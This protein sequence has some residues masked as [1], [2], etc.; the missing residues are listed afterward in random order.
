MSNKAGCR[1]IAAA[2]M[3][4][5]RGRSRSAY[6]TSSASPMSA[7]DAGVFISARIAGS[8]ASVTVW[9][10]GWTAASNPHT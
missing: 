5:Q 3:T 10:A 9:N 6:A 7:T 4:A 1:A 2:P 8:D